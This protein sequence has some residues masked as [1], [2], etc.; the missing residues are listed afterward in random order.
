MDQA[1]IGYTVAYSELEQEK[2]LLEERCKK[3]EADM[4]KME[5]LVE[6][7]VGVVECPVCLV[8]P[9]QGGPVP[10]CPNGHFVCRTCRDRLRQDAAA[11]PVKCPSC[12]VDLGDA[13]SLLA[14]RLVEGVKHQCEHFGCEEMVD[15]AQLEKHLRDCGYRKVLCPGDG[16]SCTTTLSFNKIE[17]H[18]L[19]CEDISHQT[20]DNNSTRE[21]TFRFFRPTI[22]KAH[23]KMFFC[24]MNKIQN[25]FFW[26]IVMLGSEEECKGYKASLTILKNDNSEVLKSTWCPRPIDQ[27]RTGDV[28]L[29]LPR[30]VFTG[31]IPIINFNVRIFI[32][33]IK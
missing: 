23:G 16:I 22:V 24:R 19:T 6:E 29:Y 26:E 25:M 12:T 10:V 11:E 4:K 27:R 3:M 9:N 33:K 1:I 14:S 8:L 28:G 21:Y 5:G 15:F 13:T 30:E 20:L 18:V 7:L 2:Q 31:T 32:D 17:E